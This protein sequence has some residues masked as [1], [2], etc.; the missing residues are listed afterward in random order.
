MTSM[1]HCVMRRQ[2]ACFFF[3]SAFLIAGTSSGDSIV[4]SPVQSAT[5]TDENGDGTPEVVGLGFGHPGDPNYGT[6]LV[7]KGGGEF[8]YE[9]RSVEEFSLSGISSV[10]SAT[11]TFSFHNAADAISTTF[12]TF[13]S[14]SDGQVQLSDYSMS[15]MALGPRTVPATQNY[16]ISYDVTTA[17]NL[18]LSSGGSFASVRQQIVGASGGDEVFSPVL[19]I[20]TASGPGSATWKLNPGSGDWNTASNWMPATVPNG[21]SDVATSYFFEHNRR[22]PFRPHG[23]ERHTVQCRR[24]SVHD[25]R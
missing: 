1:F 13:L 16:F 17:L 22:L 18:V 6:T 19:N 10:Q 25:H 15:S 5:I 12:E 14:S 24:E 3:F 2:V 8:P 4:L 23:S 11:L 20:N 7:Q 21:P 9:R